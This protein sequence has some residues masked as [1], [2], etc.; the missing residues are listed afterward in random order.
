MQQMLQQLNISHE[1]ALFVNP[2]TDKQQ[3]LLST[4]PKQ[5]FFYFSSHSVFCSESKTISR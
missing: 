5:V 4:V 2:F 1:E 3:D